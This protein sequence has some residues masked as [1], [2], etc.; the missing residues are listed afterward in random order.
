MNPAQEDVIILR[1][2]MYYVGIYTYARVFEIGNLSK[3]YL[4]DIHN[5]SFAILIINLN[6]P[7][8]GIL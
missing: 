6:N 5:L 1:I 2:A 8:K 7:G 3:F 4:D